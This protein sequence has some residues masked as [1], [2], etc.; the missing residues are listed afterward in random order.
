MTTTPK[1]YTTAAF[2]RNR[3]K[4]IPAAA[5][6]SDDA[7]NEFIVAAEGVID[8]VTG[9]DWKSRFV[10]ATHRLIEACATDIA[11]LYC[12]C[13]DPSVYTDLAEATSIADILW[14]QAYRSL[15]ILQDKR[16]VEFLKGGT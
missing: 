13:N 14:A 11:A 16:V 8:A 6:L 7:I 1:G 15:L 9:E 2:V 4:N 12:V 10:Q 3:V 5:T